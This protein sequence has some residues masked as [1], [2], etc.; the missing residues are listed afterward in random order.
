MGKFNLAETGLPNNIHVYFRAKQ[1]EILD[2]YTAARIFLKETE[3]NDWNHWVQSVD[4]SEARQVFQLRHMS[5]FYEVALMYYNIV[6]DMSWVLCYIS[7]EV[8]L[9][10]KGERISFAGMK[11]IEEAA[12]LLRTAE[13]SITNPAVEGNPLK[14]FKAICPELSKA[15]DRVI[16][17]WNLYGNST[18]R[19]R[20]NFCKHKGKPAYKELEEFRG[21]R[22]MNIYLQRKESDD[23]FQLVSDISDVQLHFSLKEAIAELREF[24]DNTLYS[25]IK[26]LFEELEDILNPLPMI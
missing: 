13:N 9:E 5:Y 4:D 20:Y 15:I 26:G 8:S 23:K 18:I 6:V 17:F 12:V 14:Y 7:S 11:T 22:L 19:K 3:T 24:D 2:Q 21:P 16:E 10:R 1:S 25:Y